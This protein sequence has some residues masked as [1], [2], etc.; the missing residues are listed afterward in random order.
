MTNEEFKEVLRE[1]GVLYSRVNAF[2]ISHSGTDYAI[3]GGRIPLRLARKI[4]EGI[5]N[6]KL[7]I[8][9]HGSTINDTPEDWATNTDLMNMLSE[10]I[11]KWEKQPNF[12]LDEAYKEKKSEYIKKLEEENRINEIY[13]LHYHI[14][15]KEGMAH[16]INCIREMRCVNTG[17]YN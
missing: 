17:Y 2:E 15:T 12:D 4:N 13:I 10:L 1:K 11:E 7:Q 8:C 9:V 5:D 16:V 3:L 14:H 6:S